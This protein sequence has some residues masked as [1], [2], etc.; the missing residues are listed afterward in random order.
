VDASIG[1][2]ME[3]QLG[4]I[5]Q[6]RATNDRIKSFGAM[7][8]WDHSKAN[9]DLMARARSQGITLPA[10]VGKENQTMIDNLS[11]KTGE[12]FNKVYMNMMFEDHLKDIASFKQA[13]ELCTNPSIK[14]F[15]SKA[16]P[17]LD[18]HLDFA[19]AITERI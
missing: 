9:E 10:N 12:S 6:D 13:A 14:D 4:Q 7:M 1:G 11:K 15:A 18:K 17:I 3:I 19:K 2:M 16:L 5:A 8:V